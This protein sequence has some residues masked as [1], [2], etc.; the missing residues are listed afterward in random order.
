[1]TLSEMLSEPKV[2]DN[3]GGNTI[4]VRPRAVASLTFNVVGQQG[5]ILDG[6]YSV[7]CV[8]GNDVRVA[9]LSGMEESS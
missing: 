3:I 1:M 9:L 8:M 4:S 2:V 6:R 5:A 7:S